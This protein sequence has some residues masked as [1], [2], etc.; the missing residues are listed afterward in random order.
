MIGSFGVSLNFG[1]N[2]I[3]LWINLINQIKGLIEEL[4]SFKTLLRL[5]LI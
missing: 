2:L 4:V 3:K 1:I 5:K